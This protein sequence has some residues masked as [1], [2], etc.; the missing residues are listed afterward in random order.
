[1]RFEWPKIDCFDRL[2]PYLS[3]EVLVKRVRFMRANGQPR[4][5]S[6]V[7]DLPLTGYD[8]GH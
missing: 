4:F 6:A 8:D 5:L 7:V 1:M 3:I 2:T